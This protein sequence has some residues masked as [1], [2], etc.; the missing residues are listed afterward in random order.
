MEEL[1]TELDTKLQEVKNPTKVSEKQKPW[2]DISVYN[3]SDKY[4]LFHEGVMIVPINEPL[5]IDEATGTKI[6]KCVTLNEQQENSLFEDNDYI[7]WNLNVWPVEGTYQLVD[8][9]LDVAKDRLTGFVSE[10]RNEKEISGVDITIQ[11]K[12]VKAFTGPVARLNVIQKL[13]QLE[14][15]ETTLY[16]FM[17][18][19]WLTIDRNELELI[20]L[21][22]QQHI[23]SLDA[24]EQNINSQIKNA[25]TVNQLKS[26]EVE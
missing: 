5:I 16:K 23:D 22:V 3:Y 25:T 15:N 14:N 12:T 11:N 2:V 8:R 20:N 26:I 21:A 6:Y 19:E 10:I 18:N 4:A 13:N 9:P 17:D 1:K 7:E 24:W